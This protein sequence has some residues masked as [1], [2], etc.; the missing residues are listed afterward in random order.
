[1]P[2]VPDFDRSTSF[3]NEANHLSSQ[4]AKVTVSPGPKMPPSTIISPDHSTGSS[5]SSS[6][7]VSSTEVEED[8]SSS[9][10]KAILQSD[11]KKAE[12]A[13]RFAPEP[14][15]MENP[16]RFVLFPIQDNEVR[17]KRGK[18]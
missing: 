8:I 16:S 10:G 14:L 18:L 5:V 4:M 12:L 15:L 6:S 11:H 1:M 3:L 13:G 17:Q 2:I 7:S 9:L